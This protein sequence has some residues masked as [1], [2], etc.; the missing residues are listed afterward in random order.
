MAGPLTY[1]GVDLLIP[2][3][4]L[5]AYASTRYTIADLIPFRFSPRPDWTTISWPTPWDSF[6]NQPVRSNTLYWP[7]GA[8]RWGMGFFWCA[9][10][11]LADVRTVVYGEAGDEYNAATLSMDDGENTAVETSMWMLPPIPV[12]PQKVTYNASDVATHGLVSWLVPVTQADTARERL[13]DGQPAYLL[14][15]VDARYFWWLKAG[16][17]DVTAGTT[18]W[19]QVYTAIASAL[20]ISITVETVN[21]A[22]LKPPAELSNRYTHLPLLLDAVAHCVGQRFVRKLDGTCSTV[23]PVAAKAALAVQL[24]LDYARTG[25]GLL[26]LDI[27]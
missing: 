11:D 27:A 8:S 7:T 20:G 5:T 15:L 25:G 13:Q 22:Y 4:E 19:A 10:E 17:I 14:P 3:A 16:N 9:E 1:G 2:S 24:A 18:T 23:G 26:A 6:R 21:S 12:A